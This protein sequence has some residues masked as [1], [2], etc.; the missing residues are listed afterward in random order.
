LVQADKRISESPHVLLDLLCGMMRTQAIHHAA[1]L[2]IAELVKDGP[3]SIFELAE[4][5]ETH[6]PSLSR[7]L[8]ALASIDIFT[9]VAPECF[10][11]TP[12]SSLLLPEVPGSMYPIALLHGD[13]WQWHIWEGFASSLQT[14]QPAFRKL[15]GT[16]MWQY[17]AQEN[18]AAGQ[19][20][21]DAMTGL[22]EQVNEAI[23]AAMYDFASLD[24]IVDVGGGE[25]TLLEKLLT[26]HPTIRQ[27]ILFDHPSVIARART[28]LAT[29]GFADRYMFKSGDFFK[30]VPPGADAYLMKQIIKDW[31]DEE[32]IQI[33]SNCRRAMKPG[34]RVLVVETV[35]LPGNGT[36]HEKFIDLQLMV[37]LPGQERYE[38]QFRRLFEAAGFRLTKIVPTASP[39][40][41]LEGVAA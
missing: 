14:G 34:G 41:I 26:V 2:R 35:L 17:F 38:A 15:F 33:L 16:D 13:D 7:L 29:S 3:K 11:Q 22:S 5:T 1:R 30:E 24:I 12:L 37:L 21:Q 27:G 28:R 36:S 40:S 20:F 10:A 25:G 9:E 4:A 18:P 19:R 6:A 8:R 32:C 39:Y 31:N 23:A